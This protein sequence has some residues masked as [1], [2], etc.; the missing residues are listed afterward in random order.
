MLSRESGHSKV[1]SVGLFLACLVTTVFLS[2]VPLSRL[3]AQASAQSSVSGVSV[4]AS[5][6]VFRR[7][8]RWMPPASIPMKA[9]WPKCPR[10]WRYAT[11]CSTIARPGHGRAP[12][13]LSRSQAGRSRRDPFPL[14]H[15]RAGGGPS[16]AFNYLLEHEVLPPDVLAIEEFQEILQNFY[17][18]AHLDLRWQ[19]VQPEYERAVG[20][21]RSARWPPHRDRL[22]RLSSRN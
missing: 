7:C 21:D 4:E 6:Q 22:Q 12:R 19:R 2:S 9:R 17:K 5:E 13:L 11:D 1:F 20:R 15:F 18:E 3:H 10:A 16:A 14:Y 8:A